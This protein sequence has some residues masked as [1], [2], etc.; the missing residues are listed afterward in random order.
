MTEG[1][2]RPMSPGRAT[3]GIDIVGLD[4]GQFPTLSSE[5]LQ[6]MSTV[7]H[8]LRAYETVIIHSHQQRESVTDCSTASI[9]VH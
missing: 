3:L 6:V 4:C 2:S 1:L 9:R 7:S 5:S 8:I